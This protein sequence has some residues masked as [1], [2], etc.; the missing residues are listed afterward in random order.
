[1]RDSIVAIALVAGTA[2]AV[3]YGQFQVYRC[4]VGNSQV[5]NYVT[6]SDRPCEA[7]IERNVRTDGRIP[8]EEAATVRARTQREPSETIERDAWASQAQNQRGL[9]QDK[10]GNV[11]DTIYPSDN[12]KILGHARD[13]WDY[14]SRGQTKA[15]QTTRERGTAPST[16]AAWETEKI[17]THNSSGWGRNTRLYATNAEGT[18]QRDRDTNTLIVNG[19]PFVR[20]GPDGVVEPRTG[21]YCPIVG[22]LVFCN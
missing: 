1:M 6:Y 3:A 19:V 9:A 15:E 21:K 11:V 4:Q 5:G 7:G 12:E 8:P 2:C 17:T 13:G 16:G 22:N 14:K 20:S 10:T 18:R